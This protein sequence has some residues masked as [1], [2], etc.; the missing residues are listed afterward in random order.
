MFSRRSCIG[1]FYLICLC[2]ITQVSRTA[3][4]HCLRK[5]RSPALFF[6]VLSNFGTPAFRQVVDIPVAKNVE[7]EVVSRAMSIWSTTYGRPRASESEF[8]PRR[9]DHGCP[10]LKNTSKKP[11]VAAWIRARRLKLTRRAAAEARALGVANAASCRA[12][13]LWTEKHDKEMA[14]AQDCFFFFHLLPP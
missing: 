1:E 14:F 6:N 13:A 10:R 7:R 8:R 11:S 4:A 12:P 5:R 3:H 2:H 9:R